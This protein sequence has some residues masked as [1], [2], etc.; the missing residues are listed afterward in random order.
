MDYLFK[1]SEMKQQTLTEKA[2]QFQRVILLNRQFS[3]IYDHI[4]TKYDFIFIFLIFDIFWGVKEDTA[5]ETSNNLI[6]SIDCTDSL[7]LNCTS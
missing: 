5:W 6:L 4:F 1:L 7:I 3:Y 2:I